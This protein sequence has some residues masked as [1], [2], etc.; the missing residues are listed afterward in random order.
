MINIFGYYV[1]YVFI[2][3]ALADLAVMIGGLFLYTVFGL[4]QYASVTPNN[5]SVFSLSTLS[6]GL[7]LLFL[8]ATGIY[9]RRALTDFRLTM[10]RLLRSFIFAVPSVT[11]LWYLSDL[12][13]VRSILIPVAAMGIQF[14]LLALTRFGLKLLS[15]GTLFGLRAVILAPESY[16]EA[17]DKIAL[18]SRFPLQILRPSPY[19][20]LLTDG[21]FDLAAYCRKENINMLIIPGSVTVFPIK[22][23]AAC[24]FDG[25]EILDFSFFAERELGR[26]EPEKVYPKWIFYSSALGPKSFYRFLKRIFDLVFALAVIAITAPVQAV[27]AF[28][29][30]KH[31]GGPVFYTQTRTGLRGAPFAI[32]KFRSMCVDAEKS[33]AQ[34]ARQNDDRI[35][36]IGRFIRKTRLDELPQFFN[37][38]KGEMSVVGPRP[39]RPE[40]VEQLA[41]EIP[42]YKERHYVKPGLTGWAQINADYGASVEDAR[43][44]LEYDLYYMKYASFTLDALI[45]LKTLKVVLE[46]QG[47][48]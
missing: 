18:K 32:Y 24:R 13:Y 22:Q 34:W 17:A 27:I 3:L 48:R 44:K 16:T 33:G 4:G 31:D 38:L 42:F 5:L 21:D 29:I 14:C 15:P 45:A 11:L 47:A 30:K 1:H 28:L 36:P 12:A 25:V 35:T 39:E 20:R 23:L 26:V 43:R 41:L 40:F 46:G 19:Q 8:Y 37:I 10:M 2:I 6:A 9:E 7:T